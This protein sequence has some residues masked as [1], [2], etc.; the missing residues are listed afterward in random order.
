MLQFYRSAGCQIVRCLSCWTYPDWTLEER[1]RFHWRYTGERNLSIWK[2]IVNKLFLSIS[3]LRQTV[4]WRAACHLVMWMYKRNQLKRKISDV[5]KTKPESK[6]YHCLSLLQHKSEP[7]TIHLV[8]FFL[9]R[10][11]HSLSKWTS[12]VGNVLL[13]RQWIAA[14]L[15]NQLCQLMSVKWRAGSVELWLLKSY[16]LRLIHFVVCVATGP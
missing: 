12:A 5:W 6:K 15:R 1:W 13:S 9:C 16:E 11:T 3:I 8:R 2:L 7:P 14:T 10:M 4:E